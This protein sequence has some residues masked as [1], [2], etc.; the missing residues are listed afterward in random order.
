MTTPVRDI[1]AHLVVSSYHTLCPPWGVQVSRKRRSHI[2]GSRCFA[3]HRDQDENAAV[4]KRCNFVGAAIQR[5]TLIYSPIC[6]KQ[7]TKYERF[8]RFSSIS[9][10]S[11]SLGSPLLPLPGR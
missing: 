11:C 4:R 3:A 7:L 1:F 10:F 9:R 2:P 6:L 5:L 8:R